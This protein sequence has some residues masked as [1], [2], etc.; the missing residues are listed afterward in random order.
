MYLLAHESIKSDFQEFKC[1]VIE[2]VRQSVAVAEKEDNSP[3][4]SFLCFSCCFRQ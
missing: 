1:K 3:R 4:R 2:E